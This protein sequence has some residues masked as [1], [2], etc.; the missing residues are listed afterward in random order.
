M[1]AGVSFYDGATFAGVSLSAAK[2]TRQLGADDR[3]NPPR[4]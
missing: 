2:R 1:I 3:G 4:R